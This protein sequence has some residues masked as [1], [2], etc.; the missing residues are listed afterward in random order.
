MIKLLC[1][2]FHAMIHSK[3]FWLGGAMILTIAIYGIID[4]SR[5]KE[6]A[7]FEG[8]LDS[9]VFQFVIILF[10]ILPALG[11]LFI[12]TDYYDGT[13]RNKLTIGRSRA[14]VYLANLITVYGVG[15]F[16]MALNM[17]AC[18]A[19]GLPVLGNFSQPQEI[20]DKMLLLLLVFLSLSALFTMLATLIANRSVLLVCVFM[21]F[22]LILSAQLVNS[23]LE[24]PEM[25]DDYGGVSM[26][27]MEDG[28][29]KTEYLDKN[30][31]PIKPEDIPRVPNPR[32]VKEPMRTVLRTVNNIQPGGQMLEIL[33]GGHQEPDQTIAQTPYWQMALYALILSL[34][35]TGAGIVLFRRKDLK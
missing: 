34:I 22:G 7:D 20:V 6:I 21:A 17:A 23:M 25:I 26:T 16:Y 24:N 5:M 30:G 10:L 27:T 31:N 1:A 12:N 33:E 14:E 11:S 13:I 8:Q 29:M 2:N 3:R 9:V 18:L 19:V 15:L 32:Y 4:T 28:T 35:T